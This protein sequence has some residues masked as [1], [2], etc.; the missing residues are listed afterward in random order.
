MREQEDNSTYNTVKEW[1]N[2]MKL[3]LIFNDM[4]YHNR[5]K[6]GLKFQSCKKGFLMYAYM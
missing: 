5:Y 6:T 2:F 3:G 1:I 4:R